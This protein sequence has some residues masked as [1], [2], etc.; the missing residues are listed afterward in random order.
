MY[1]QCAEVSRATG[2]HTSTEVANQVLGGCL[3][4]CESWA[5]RMANSPV[6]MEVHGSA[7]KCIAG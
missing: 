5:I 4:L 1:H 7:W 3:D 6:R 2:I